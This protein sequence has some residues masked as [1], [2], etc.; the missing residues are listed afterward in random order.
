MHN[1]LYDH[2]DAGTLWERHRHKVLLGLGF[3]PV[4]NF[5]TVY[6]DDM[7]SAL[8]NVELEL[9][10]LFED[11]AEW[12]GRMTA[13]FTAGTGRTAAGHTIKSWSFY[14]SLGGGGD[15]STHGKRDDGGLFSGF[16]N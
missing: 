13:G 10:D 3:E 16:F 9:R 8:I 15:G 5:L 2:P 4:P 14:E 1:A 7:Q 11:G 12:D 6:V